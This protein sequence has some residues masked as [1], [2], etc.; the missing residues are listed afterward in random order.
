MYNYSQLSL[1]KGKQDFQVFK[2][3]RFYYRIFTVYKIRFPVMFSGQHSLAI[4]MV[5][6]GSIS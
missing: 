4:S 6:N 2:N 5:Q 3:K 1:E